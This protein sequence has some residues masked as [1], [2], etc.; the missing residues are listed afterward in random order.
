VVI[1]LFL[2]TLS[3]AFTNVWFCLQ[4]WDTA[5]GAVVLELGVKSVN[6]EAW[7]LL[8][9]GQGD[10]A[11]FHGVTN[12]VHQYSRASGFKSKCWIIC[13]LF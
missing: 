13:V 1:W 9:W 6:K 3:H 11:A 5:T 12:T 10:E 8:Q 2:S 7:P 4:A